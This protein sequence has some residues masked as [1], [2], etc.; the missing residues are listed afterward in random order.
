MKQILNGAIQFRN[1]HW[2]TWTCSLGWTVEGILYFN[3]LYLNQD[4]KGIYTQGSDGEVN[5][6]DRSHNKHPGGYHLVAVGE[7][8]GKVRVLRYPSRNKGSE[9]VE[10]KGH[11]GGVTG[12]RWAVGDEW[13]YSVGGEDN[14]VFMWKKKVK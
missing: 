11:S 1:Q 13:L 3:D 12:I 14:C 2:A 9:A 5:T 10:G 4:F 8:N 7:E 6:V